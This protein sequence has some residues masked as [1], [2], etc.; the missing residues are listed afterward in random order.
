MKFKV[1]FRQQKKNCCPPQTYYVV[2]NIEIDA[3]SEQ[4]AITKIKTKYNGIEIIEVVS[5]L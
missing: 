4:D 5:Q 2:H 1:K 3:N